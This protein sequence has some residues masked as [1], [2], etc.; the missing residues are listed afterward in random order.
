M[1]SLTDFLINSYYKGEHQFEK[2]SVM[3][4]K[5][6]VEKHFQ[7]LYQSKTEIKYSAV[8]IYYLLSAETWQ[9][10]EKSIV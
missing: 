1:N 5:Y 8:E 3:I 6:Q 9:L 4:W 2:R 10:S 7:K